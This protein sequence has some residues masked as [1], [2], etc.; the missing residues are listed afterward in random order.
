MKVYGVVYLLIDSTNDY[1]YVG[2]TKRSVEKRFKEHASCKKSLIGKA[3]NAHGA[4]MF[5]I[6]ILKVCYS[7]EEMDSCERHM[8]RSRDTKVP[9][10][11]NLTD[12]GEGFSGLKH[13]PE[14]NAKI[15]AAN[16]G[17][18]K[19]S[20]CRAKLALIKT[21]TA[22]RAYSP[23]STLFMLLTKHG[24]SY[25]ELA[26][27]LD[28]TQEAMSYKMCGEHNFSLVQMEAIRNFLGVDIPLAELFRKAD[29][30]VPDLTP[31]TYV[32]PVLAAE[33]Q[34]R[35]I[36]HKKIGEALHLGKSSIGFKMRGKVGFSDEQKAAIRDFLGIDMPLEELF[37]RRD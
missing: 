16:K 13:T 11:Y 12:G 21:L 4:E 32:Y 22:K 10:G 5:I 18:P 37:K 15:A 31:K 35:K 33:L 27:T 20:E 36:T 2:Q 9:N 29:G 30:S 6:V 19:S 26:K 23:Y 1:E 14:H 34:K 28:I 7:K 8:I 3:I 25:T 17:V 24:I